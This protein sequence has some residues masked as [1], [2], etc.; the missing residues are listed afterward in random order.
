MTVDSVEV[1]YFVQRGG[2]RGPR[3]GTC[4]ISFTGKD[5]RFGN[6]LAGYHFA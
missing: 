1:A 4:S 5:D 3:S 6:L 2:K